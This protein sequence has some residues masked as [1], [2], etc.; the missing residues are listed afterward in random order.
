MLGRSWV[1]IDLDRIA[2]NY[3]ICEKLLRPGQTIMAVMKADA[4]GHG[5]TVTAKLLQE[6]CGCRSFAVSNIEEAEGL[7]KAGVDGQILILGYTPL[8]CASELLEYDITQALLSEEYAQLLLEVAGEK[9]SK[10]KAQFAID[11]GMKR[12]GLDSSDPEGCEAVIRKFAARFDMTGIF[13]HIAAADN[14][15]EDEFSLGQIKSF[16]EISERL[17]DLELP[18]VHYMNSAA[19]LRHNTQAVPLSASAFA[20]LGIVLYGL[21]PDA[22]S[23][24]PG[25]IKPALAWRSV[26]AM[27]KAVRAGESIGY[28]RSFS[29]DRDMTVATVPTGYADG[30]RRSLSNKGFVIIAGCRCRVVGRVC[31]DQLMADVTELQKLIDCGKAPAGAL[32][33]GSEVSLLSDEYSADDMAEDISSISYEIICGI[34]KR[35]PRKYLQK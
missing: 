13:T 7:R 16:I 33:I 12:I 32:D 24:M 35:V 4:Y 27:V 14:A 20:R 22:S 30:Y 15:S 9:A 29:A 11:T 34:S 31:M 3:R 8:S 26:I 28:G 21:K 10:L 25:G 5:D 19:G 1:E 18:C 2:E 17:S 23:L 6:R